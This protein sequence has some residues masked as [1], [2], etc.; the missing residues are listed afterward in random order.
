M[1][2]DDELIQMQHFCHNGETNCRANLRYVTT[3]LYGTSTRGC[4]NKTIFQKEL[5]SCFLLSTYGAHV[6]LAATGFGDAC[7]S[8]KTATL[9]NSLFFVFE[10]SLLPN[11]RVKCYDYIV[12]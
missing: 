10:S 7:Q 11:Y 8:G 6:G 5:F 4:N 12:T 1:A 2:R 3:K 9:L